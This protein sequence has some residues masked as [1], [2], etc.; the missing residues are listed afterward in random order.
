MCDELCEGGETRFGHFEGDSEVSE[1][2]LRRV[3]GVAF[4]LFEA[5]GSVGREGVGGCDFEVV[6][7]VV[8]LE[9]VDDASGVV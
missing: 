6:S 7:V 4:G 3:D 9:F 8:V 5:V 1:K 2:V